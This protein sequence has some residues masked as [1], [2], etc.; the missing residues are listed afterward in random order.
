[1]STS[2]EWS[3]YSRLPAGAQHVTE[4]P[5][6]ACEFGP[7]ALAIRA[8]AE[9]RVPVAEKTGSPAIWPPPVTFPGVGSGA[10]ARLGEK[11]ATKASKPPAFAGC[12]PPVVP[13][14]SVESVNPAT[15]T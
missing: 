13:G 3:L 12:A 14:K 1:M 15:Y 9:R 10:E 8:G 11:R 7:A 2:A 5:N 6:V 4:K